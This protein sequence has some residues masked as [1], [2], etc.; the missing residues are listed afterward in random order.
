MGLSRGRKLDVG[1]RIR[2]NH[3]LRNPQTEF[4]LHAHTVAAS[5]IAIPSA[6]GRM[7]NHVLAISP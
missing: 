6:G 1:A 7:L 3:A 4:A 5:K 2:K